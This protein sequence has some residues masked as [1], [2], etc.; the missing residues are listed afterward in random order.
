M[1]AQGQKCQNGKLAIFLPNSHFGTFVPVHGF[2][3]S[4]W[5]ND[6]S[7]SDMKDLFHTFALKVS[8][9]LSRAVHELLQEDK[10]DYVKFPSCD[11]KNSFCF[12]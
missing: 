9:A 6:F 8:Q 5:S 3:K 11:V 4:F 12:G 1:V 10:L 2:Q 7:L